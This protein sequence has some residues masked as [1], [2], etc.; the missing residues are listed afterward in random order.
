MFYPLCKLPCL[1]EL[2]FSN[3][4]VLLGPKVNIPAS[5]DSVR[6][7]QLNSIEILE[8]R[9]EGK[10]SK[11]SKES[12]EPKE[13]PEDSKELKKPTQLSQLAYVA[14]VASRLF[15]NV[16]TIELT[17]PSKEEMFKLRAHL[18]SMIHKFE[19]LQL[20]TILTKEETFVGE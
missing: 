13:E 8:D 19:K 9:E 14:D 17:H 10:E 15:P 20:P 3:G 18:R 16:D 11:E 2:R 6:R 7:I 1:L 4:T 5:L 12:E